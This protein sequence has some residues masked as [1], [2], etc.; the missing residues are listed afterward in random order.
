MCQTLYLF[1]ITMLHLSR[2]RFKE[3]KLLVQVHAA[4]SHWTRLQM[5]LAPDPLLFPPCT[6]KS[7]FV[8][9]SEHYYLTSC[10]TS[11]ESDWFLFYWIYDYF[12]FDIVW[13]EINI[14]LLSLLT[15]QH[16]PFGTPSNFFTLAL[17]LAELDSDERLVLAPPSFFT[18]GRLL[19]VFSHPEHGAAKRCQ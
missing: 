2:M 16:V 14:A 19:Q 5:G 9:F 13:G 7:K 1:Y 11:R 3:V 6:L 18:S 15:T 17:P 8:L 10:T 12:Q 4:L